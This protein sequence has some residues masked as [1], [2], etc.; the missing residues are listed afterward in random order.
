MTTGC[1]W[2]YTTNGDRPISEGKCTE[3]QMCN[4]VAGYIEARI[5]QRTAYVPKA[6]VRPLRT[7]LDV[8]IVVLAMLAV[9]SST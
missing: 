8:C 7:S 4:M 5:K 6:M 1:E 9:Q 2:C 3:T